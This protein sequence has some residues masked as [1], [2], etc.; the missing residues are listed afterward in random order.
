MSKKINMNYSALMQMYNE[1]DTW[2]KRGSVLYAFNTSKINEFMNN[3]GVR[4]Q[5]FMDRHNA[6][7][8]S[9]YEY[10]SRIMEGGKT[11]TVP[12]ME[13]EA[14]HM[15]PKFQEGKTQEEYNEAIKALFAEETVVVL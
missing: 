6:L 11:E 7:D 1:I 8:R 4:I 12:V 9:F 14:P 10:E 5:S 15:K 13:G 2:R 3:N